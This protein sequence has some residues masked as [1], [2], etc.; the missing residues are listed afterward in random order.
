MNQPE[1]PEKFL[2]MS[3]DIGGHYFRLRMVPETSRS[4]FTLITVRRLQECNMLHYFTPELIQETY[5]YMKA[6]EPL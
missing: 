6:T 4:S 2:Y 1:Q 3:V 5:D